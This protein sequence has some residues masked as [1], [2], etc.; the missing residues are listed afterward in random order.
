MDVICA[1][2]VGGAAAFPIFTA[3]HC[4]HHFLSCN[5]F[6]SG[7]KTSFCTSE[8]TIVLGKLLTVRQLSFDIKRKMLSCC[9]TLV[10]TYGS[11]SWTI[12]N[13]EVEIINEAGKRF[14]R[15]M[16]KISYIER[17][18]ETILKWPRTTRLLY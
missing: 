17:T 5:L 9:V 3:L 6:N 14:L 2:V 13:T 18:N 8:E 1:H 4:F 12:S 10:V 11:E 7:N 15:N 16:L